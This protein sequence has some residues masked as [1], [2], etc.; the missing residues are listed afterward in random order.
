MHWDLPSGRLR[1]R[2]PCQIDFINSLTFTPDSKALVFS[3]FQKL[4][5]DF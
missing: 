4:A 1:E 3:G 2:Y 5:R